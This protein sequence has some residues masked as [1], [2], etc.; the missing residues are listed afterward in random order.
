MV[1][2]AYNLSFWVRA[3]RERTIAVLA[4]KGAPDW[5]YYGLWAEVAVTTE[6]QQVTVPF[7]ST[8]TATD[9]SIQLLLGTA[10]GS[11]WIDGVTLTERPPDVYRR[12]FT[13]GTVLLNGT[14][15]P[16]EVPLGP[17]FRRLTGD[18]APRHQVIVDDGDPAFTTTGSW[19]ETGFESGELA[20]SGPFYHDWGSGCRVGSGAVSEASW[21]ITV[22]FADTYTVAAWWAGRARGYG[23]VS[24]RAVRDRGGRRR[25]G[26][27][28]VRP[29]NDRGPVPL[30]RPGCTRP[31]LHG[32][33]SA[34]LPGR[35]RLRRRRAPRHLGCPLQR[36]QC[37]H[38]GDTGAA[39]RDRPQLDQTR[40]DPPMS[41]ATATWTAP[42][43]WR[44]CAPST[45]SPPPSTVDLGRRRSR[46]QRD[47]SIAVTEISGP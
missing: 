45:A 16:Q 14:G 47:L 20:G 39:G 10:V 29:T 44:S 38:V 13:H 46:R 35:C 22:P 18:Q 30:H 17:G 1:D 42:T 41:I 34:P 21:P 6:W 40:W 15:E 32:P 19:V 26:L 31:G 7:T 37:G 12:D 24:L 11:V 36:R 4:Q 27:G 33:G 23:L 8:A 25:C 43:S 28:D 2:T 9:A 3:D 5:D